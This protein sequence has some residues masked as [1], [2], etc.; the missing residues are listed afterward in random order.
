MEQIDIFVKNKYH[1]GDCIFILI[2]FKQIEE[3]IKE[4]NIF[5]HFYCYQD[6]VTQVKD[7]N[8]SNNVTIFSLTELSHVKNNVY[9]LWIGSPENKYNWFKATTEPIVPY[10]HFFIK[11]YNTF[12]E[13]IQIPVKLEKFT[14]KSDY[15]IDRC[16]EI[17]NMTNNKYIGIDFLINNGEP[18]SYQLD[19]HCGD[20]NNFVINLSKKYKVVTTQKVDNILCTRDDNLTVKDIAAISLNIKNFIL[21]ESGVTVGLYNEYMSETEDVTVYHLSNN[22]YHKTSFKNWKFYNNLNSISFLVQNNII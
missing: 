5:I 9:D 15:L 20:W 19:Y 18:K 8:E 1:L 6:H 3:Y 13:V 7:F 4:N 14:Y 2:C 17:N 16:N 21:I 11:F 10:D 12:L 22:I